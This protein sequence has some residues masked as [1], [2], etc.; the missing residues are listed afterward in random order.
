VCAVR[1][2]IGVGTTIDCRR[3]EVRSMAK[4]EKRDIKKDKKDKRDK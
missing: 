3:E 4:K 1:L 2:R